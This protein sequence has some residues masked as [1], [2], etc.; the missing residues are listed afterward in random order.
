MVKVAKGLDYILIATTALLAVFGI[1]VLA[2]TSTSAPQ[3]GEDIYSLLKHQLLF[4]LIPGILLAFLF[5][6]KIDLKFLKQKSSIFLLASLILMVLVFLPQIGGR[7]GQAA[8]WISLKYFTFQPSEILK[9]SFILYLASWLASKTKRVSQ[10][11]SPKN[12][13][14]NLITFLIILGVIAILLL[15]QSDIGTLGVILAT[16]G[17]MYFFAKT[18]LWHIAFVGLVVLIGFSLFIRLTPYRSER[19]VTFLNPESDPMGSGYQIKQALIAVGSGKIFGLGFGMSQ[20]KFGLLPH[21]FSDS[22]FAI[23]AEEAGFA[24][25][26]ILVLLFL[27]FLWRGYKIGKES[28]DMFSQLTALGIT[29]WILIQSFVN[30]GSMIGILP[31]TG[32][33]LPFISHGGS[34]LIAELVGVGILLNIAKSN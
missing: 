3:T 2:S 19:I 26:F 1:V 29:S 17:L 10:N 16:A 21:P 14:E 13:K 4:A 24:G 9:I 32:I 7:S 5:A 33:P 6:T 23:F 25:S 28:K 27:L 8:R 22:I 34:A 30:I 20:Q 31:L 18:P 11:R 15:L 12:P